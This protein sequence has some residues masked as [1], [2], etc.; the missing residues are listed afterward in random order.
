M[1]ELP[2]E[3]L[4][5]HFSRHGERMTRRPALE[6]LTTHEKKQMRPFDGVPT[7]HTAAAL[8]AAMESTCVGFIVLTGYWEKIFI[9]K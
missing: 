4:W 1:S 3:R 2:V 7:A 8:G 6:S 5:G 9:Y